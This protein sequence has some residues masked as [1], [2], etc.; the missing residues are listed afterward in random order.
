MKSSF[1][2]AVHE[3]REELKIYYQRAF[4]RLSKALGVEAAKEAKA[5]KAKAE[6][7]AE[8]EER[9]DREGLIIFNKKKRIR[10][11]R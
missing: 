8:V 7:Q 5:A 10:R 3:Y 2:K 9:R 6:L 11:V 1:N 4:K